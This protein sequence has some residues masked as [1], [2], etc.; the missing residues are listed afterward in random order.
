MSDPEGI[1]SFGRLEV[2]I[3]TGHRDTWAKYQERCG[4]MFEVNEITDEGKKRAVLLS[5]CGWETSSTLKT[6]MAPEKPSAKMYKEL[7]TA[8]QGHSEPEP[9]EIMQHFKF[10][11]LIQ[12]NGE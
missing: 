1:D 5:V 2:F 11:N 7:C 12:N 9:S 4:Q 6:L 3:L 10:F 8:M